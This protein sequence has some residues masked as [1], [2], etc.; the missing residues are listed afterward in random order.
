MLIQIRTTL[1]SNIFALSFAYQLFVVSIFFF[2]VS[3]LDVFGKIIVIGEN[4]YLL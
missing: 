3:V 1:L 2:S 4:Y